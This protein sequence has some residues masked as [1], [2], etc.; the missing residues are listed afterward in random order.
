MTD[1]ERYG[2]GL[3]RRESRAV[4]R[5]LAQMG[6]RAQIALGRIEIEADLQAARVHSVAYVGKQAMQATA[7]V[8]ELE[9]QL[10]QMVPRAKGRLQ[11]IADITTLGLAEIVA[12]TVRKVSH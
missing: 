9:G 10:G 1:L 6:T 4:S 3:A 2:G 5:Q 7:I 12:D 11:G 8:S